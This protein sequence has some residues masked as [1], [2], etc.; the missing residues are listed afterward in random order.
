PIS[1]G[2]TP[3]SLTFD[4]KGK[5][6]KLVVRSSPMQPSKFLDNEAV[7]A[8]KKG[9]HRT[10]PVDA[11]IGMEGP[12]KVVQD[13]LAQFDSATATKNPAADS[14]KEADGLMTDLDIKLQELSTH[15][16]GTLLKWGGDPDVGPSNIQLPRG[17][18]T[19]PR[20]RALAQ[21]HAARGAGNKDD[22]VEDSKH[23]V[24]NLDPAKNL[25]RRHVISS[26]DIAADY[27]K[28]LNGKK[29]SEGK[30]LLEQ[31]ASIPEARVPVNALK[32]DVL[33]KA[34]TKRY[35]AFFGYVR[36]LFIGDSIE[37]SI[38]QER[39]DPKHPEM[40]GNAAKLNEH[41]RHVKRVGDGSGH[42]SL[43]RQHQLK[44]PNV[45]D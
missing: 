40:V 25:A 14:S 31:R 43:R 18:F 2:D 28:S 44:M 21:A 10:V 13:K 5:S 41:I 19:V 36:N 22:L 7:R 39:I 27:M 23:R 29:V 26:H 38:L 34:A 12:I 4:G 24:I 15:I 1:G 37:N 6:A 9:T 42:G 16:S 35:N 20:K 30:I 45:R 32:V 8:K 17:E 11:V 3:H 33:Q